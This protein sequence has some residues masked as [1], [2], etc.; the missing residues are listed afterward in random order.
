M[1]E[2]TIHKDDDRPWYTVLTAGSDS[3]LTQV[4]AVKL[5]MRKQGGTK[6]VIDGVA[7]VIESQAVAS[8]NVRYDPV[9]ADVDEVGI[10][11]A[12]W[13]ATFTG[14]GTGRFPTE[15]DFD[16]ITIVRNFE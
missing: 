13:H 5:Y 2:L 4:T 8:V 9:A 11:E 16:L 7:A 10:F 6:N 12:Y 15:P 1:S 3:D 14:G